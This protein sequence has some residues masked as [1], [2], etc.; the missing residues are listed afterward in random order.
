VILL[1]AILSSPPAL[2]QID[3]DSGD[4]T[5]FAHS[6]TLPWWVSGQVNSIFQWH[7][8]FHAQ[9]SGPNSF[10]HASEQADSEVA[11]LYTGLVLS[12]SLE[13]V[14]DVENR[15]AVA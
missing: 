12:P 14:V 3:Y 8:S 15:A 11:T 5:V 7:P 13:A 2:A 1:C 6:E 4:D 10:E 9:Y